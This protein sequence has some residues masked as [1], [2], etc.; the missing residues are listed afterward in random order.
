[1]SDLDEYREVLQDPS[2]AGVWYSEPIAALDGS[3]SETFRLV[4]LAADGRPRLVRRAVRA[5]IQVYSAHLGDEFFDGQREV[6]ISYTYEALV[7]QN[8]HLF[9]L[10]IGQPT[11]GLKV[12]FQDGG[13]GLRYAHVLDYIASSHPTR[14]SRSPVDGPSPSIAVGFDGWVFPKAGVAFV[15]V[16]QSELPPVGALNTA[17]ELA[18]SRSV[19]VPAPVQRQVRLDVQGCAGAGAFTKIGCLDG[20]GTDR[21]APSITLRDG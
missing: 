1:V 19:G 17:I 21:Q 11:K 12:D 13:C 9:H 5:G 14:I 20:H 6:V 7:Q 8:S 16:L 15:W 10:D 2:V 4:Q 3:S 18:T